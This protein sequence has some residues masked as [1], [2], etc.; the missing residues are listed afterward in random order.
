MGAVVRSGT[1]RLLVLTTAILAVTGCGRPQQVSEQRTLI[2][3]KTGPQGGGFFPLGAEL[4]KRLTPRLPRVDLQPMPSAGA[5][6]NV[7]A[8]Q[9]GEAELGFTFADVAYIAYIGQLDDGQ[10]FDRMRGIAV[11][12]LT[13]I[14]LVARPDLPIESPADLKGR[15]VGV[16]P[17]GSGTALTANLIL[18]RYGLAEGSVRLESIGFQEAST[19]LMKGTLDAMFDNAINQADSLRRAIEGGARPVA[20]EGPAVDGLRRDYPFLKLAVVS[21]QMYPMLRG[22]V[23]TIGVDGVL[24]C[25]RDLDEGLVYDLTRQLFEALR[26]AGGPGTLRTLDVAQAAATPIPLHDGAARY[27]RERELSR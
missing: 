1:N 13:P 11:L 14:S 27:Y 12:Q 17:P 24:I 9:A 20:I 3:L 5:V 6:D 4:V 2:R 23:H 10:V 19:R 16:G 15:S 7:M 21:T 8:I 25:R 26:D 18:Q 22:N